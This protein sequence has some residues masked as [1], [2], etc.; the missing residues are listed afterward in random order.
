MTRTQLKE[1]VM[2]NS[3]IDFN[4]NGKR[5]GI[6]RIVKDNDVPKI[7]FWEWNNDSTLDNYYLTYDAFEANAMIDG[8]SV[9][10]ILEDIDDA[11]VF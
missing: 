6:E 3:N 8:K 9:V 11:D 2:R 5:Y 7:F 1:Y 4:F 10:A